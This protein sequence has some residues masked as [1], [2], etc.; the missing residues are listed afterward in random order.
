MTATFDNLILP[1]HI[2]ANLEQ[3]KSS[4]P[5]SVLTGFDIKSDDEFYLMRQRAPA[6]VEQTKLDCCCNF[7]LE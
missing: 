1:N 3:G 5:K 7:L 4:L 6:L 2:S